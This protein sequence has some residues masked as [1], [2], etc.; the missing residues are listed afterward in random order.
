MKF[1]NDTVPFIP[2]NY[3]YGGKKV[4]GCY[5]QKHTHMVLIMYESEDTGVLP[6]INYDTLLQ[7]LAAWFIN[8]TP[9]RNHVKEKLL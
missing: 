6:P 3:W 4:K 8:K 7:K 2:D 9:V 1:P 5:K